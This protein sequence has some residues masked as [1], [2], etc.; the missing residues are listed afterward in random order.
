VKVGRLLLVIQA[1]DWVAVSSL[2]S[3]PTK[4]ESPDFEVNA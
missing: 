1:L 3:E 2:H 4:E